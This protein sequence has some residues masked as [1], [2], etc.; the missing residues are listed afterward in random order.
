[1]RR[2]ARVRVADGVALRLLGRRRRCRLRRSSSDR[3]GSW[4]GVG[5]RLGGEMRRGVRRLM[6]RSRMRLRVWDVGW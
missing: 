4:A 1:M 5:M 2:G 6:V 3:G